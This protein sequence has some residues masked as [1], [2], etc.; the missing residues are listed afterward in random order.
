MGDEA[1]LWLYGV[2][3]NQ[4]RNARRKARREATL[5]DDVGYTMAT[6]AELPVEDREEAAATMHALARLKRQDREL[7]LLVT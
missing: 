6:V 4:L 3:R 2:A 7:V 5:V 1:I